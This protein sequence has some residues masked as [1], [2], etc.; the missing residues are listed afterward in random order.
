MQ[1]VLWVTFCWLSF[2]IDK[3]DVFIMMGLFIDDLPIKKGG[4]PYKSP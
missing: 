1:E 2:I 3:D 4:F